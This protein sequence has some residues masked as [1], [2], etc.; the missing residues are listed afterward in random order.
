MVAALKNAF[1]FPAVALRHHDIVS[2]LLRRDLAARY[3]GSLIGRI[4][5]I[6]HPLLLLGVYALVFGKMLKG[7]F[8]TKGSTL[9]VD[10]L[11]L[12]TLY[13]VPG[14]L[15]WVCTVDALNRCVP[16]IVENSNLIKKVAFPSELLPT[17]TTMVSFV[18][19]L[20]GFA[21]FIPLYAVVV[22]IGTHAD[23]A[24]AAPAG[25]ALAAGGSDWLARLASLRTLAWFPVVV[26]LQYVFVV[27]LGMLLAA[28]NVFLR[29]IGQMIPLL[30]LV[31]MFFTPIFYTQAVIENAGIA[32][33]VP[34]MKANPLFHL[35]AL[36]RGCFVYE[37][38]AVF[39]LES[40]WIFALIAA[41]V[42][43]VGHGCFHS[44]KGRF[45]DEV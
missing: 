23:P 29:D 27:G 15:T 10:A 25:A 37:S 39:P 12:S 30:T 34:A 4:W 35:L 7:D 43:V 24:T 1:R 3:E 22:L 8:Q 38:G 5:P 19:M 21:L 31:W 6:L 17:Y 28:S 13:L 36:Y 9:T 2:A 45:A 33:L 26:L 11:W 14:I 40:L 20:F 32:W 42:F 18:Q 41:G 44:W 16:I